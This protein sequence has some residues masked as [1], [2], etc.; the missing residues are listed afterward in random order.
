[1]IKLIVLM[2]ACSVHIALADTLEVT[3]TIPSRGDV[4][5]KLERRDAF[6]PGS[7]IQVMTRP[8]L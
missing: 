8:D 1:M 7:R 6:A 2:L 5:L 3:L 4:A